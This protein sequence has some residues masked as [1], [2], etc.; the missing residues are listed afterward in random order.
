[1]SAE[2]EEGAGAE[3]IVVDERRSTVVEWRLPLLLMPVTF[4]SM[5]YVGAFMEG[6]L[7][8]R[9][10]DILAGWPF[11][12][13]LMAIL[14]AHEMG[15]YV[16]GRIH[17]VDISP[18]YFIP[19]PFGVFGTL[20]AVIQM[21]G[22]ITS[23]DALLDVGVSGPL[24]GM[25]VA[26][27]VLVYG[28][29]TSEVGPN[30]YE[31]AYLL[32]GHSLF[33]EALLLAIHGGIPTGEDIHLTS[34]AF[35]GWAGLLVTMINMIPIGQLD[36]GHVA[37]ALFGP[38]QDRYSKRLLFFLPVL[39]ALVSAYY[40]AHSWIA[41]AP[42]DVIERDLGAGLPWLVWAVLLFV[43][44]TRMTGWAHPP[45]D[46]DRLSPRRR[47]VAIA[48]LVMFALLFMPAWIRTR[49]PTAPDEAPSEATEVTNE[50][51]G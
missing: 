30:E 42:G 24:A 29:A 49:G 4:A 46:D 12:V 26:V 7:V 40:G 10:Q 45:T 43:M 34:T 21:R 13:P 38:R 47:R 19:F 9:P 2:G 23:R 31:G 48:A 3:R 15:H 37:Y 22:R 33:Y 11:A 6:V 17:G 51:S 16:A 8:E 35:A 28:V 41:G 32:E 27:P 1:M 20:G 44:Q 25:A 39:A 36:G 5:L 18:P 50:A 14:F